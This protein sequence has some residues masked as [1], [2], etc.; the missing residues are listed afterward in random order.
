MKGSFREEVENREFFLRMDSEMCRT[1]EKTGT[2]GRA[3]SRVMAVCVQSS[4]GMEEQG[5]WDDGWEM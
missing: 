1:H 5:M 4:F 2:L 3:G